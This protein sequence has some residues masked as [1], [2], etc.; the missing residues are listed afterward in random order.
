MGATAREGTSF[1]SP[2]ATAHHTTNHLTDLSPWQRFWEAGAAL[3]R[4]VYAGPPW[5]AETR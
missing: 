1:A 4:L 2:R 3:Q 5:F